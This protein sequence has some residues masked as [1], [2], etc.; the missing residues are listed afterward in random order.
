MS[1][2]GAEEVA[3]SM[4]QVGHLIVENRGE[5]QLAWQA[6]EELMHT[7][8]ELNNLVDF[9]DPSKSPNE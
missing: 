1:A 3:A 8:G 5:A 6:S 4:Q 9:F 7:A 2:F